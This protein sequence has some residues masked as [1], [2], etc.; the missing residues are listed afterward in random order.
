MHQCIYTV[1]FSMASAFPPHHDHICG[2]VCRVRRRRR[3]GAFRY[4][5]RTN[6]RR[7][8]G[9]WPTLQF[10]PTAGLTSWQLS[11]PSS[12]ISCGTTCA[13]INT[14]TR[15]PYARY[16]CYHSRAGSAWYPRPARLSAWT[17]VRFAIMTRKR[18]Q[19][20]VYFVVMN[21]LRCIPFEEDSS[22]IALVNWDHVVR[23]ASG[24]IDASDENEASS[25]H[26]RSTS[27]LF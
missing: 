15:R 22:N 21:F 18:A 5:T 14:W 6:M 19:R 7:K 23:Y 10:R 17:S 8:R 3:V 9:F 16:A 25:F 4:S 27:N 1:F 12:R 11:A 13:H 24:A 20:K 26:A 2:N